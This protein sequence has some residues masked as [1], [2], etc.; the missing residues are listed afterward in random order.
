MVKTLEKKE[1]KKAKMKRIDIHAALT[2]SGFKFADLSKKIDQ[3]KKMR[4]PSSKTRNLDGAFEVKSKTPRTK[5]AGKSNQRSKKLA[6]PRF[7]HG[8][9]EKDPLPTYPHIEKILDII[10]ECSDPFEK[11]LLKTDLDSD[12]DKISFNREDFKRTLLPILK[13]NEIRDLGIGIPVKTFDEFGNCYDMIFET[14]RNAFYK[15]CNGW[16]KLLKV[17]KLKEN[18][19]CYVAVWMFRHVETDG[20]CFAL[21]LKR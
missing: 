5:F 20:L 2:L 17:H 13:G 7:G 8:I 11:K 1:E 4:S 3:E 12:K 6:K 19:D 9:D 16:K 15:L 18:E 10:G 21:I 14:Y